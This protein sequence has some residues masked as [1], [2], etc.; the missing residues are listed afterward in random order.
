MQGKDYAPSDTLRCCLPRYS[1]AASTSRYIRCI[2]AVQLQDVTTTSKTHSSR[3]QAHMKHLTEQQFAALQSAE[4]KLLW[5]VLALNIALMFVNYIDRTNL[6][7]A[8]VQLNRDI[9]L[10]KATY[11]LGAGL[12]FATYASMQVPA[13]MAMT[14]IGGPIWLGTIALCWG[15]TAACFA[16]V[17]DIPTFLALRC[18]L[19]F[20]EA[21]ALPGRRIKPARYASLTIQC[22]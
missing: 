1:Q 18:L 14:K 5:R 8:S 2:A 19:G 21:G 7:F 12:F 4:R 10:D 16:A 6:S 15:V 20:F 11:G 13:N 17:K 22:S 9:G 3:G